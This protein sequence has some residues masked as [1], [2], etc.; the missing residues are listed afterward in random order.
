MVLSLVGSQR[1]FM[2]SRSSAVPGSPDNSQALFIK[3]A[4]TNKPSKFMITRSDLNVCTI[5][6]VLLSISI[7]VIVIP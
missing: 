7:V 4:N 1:T 5:W 2:I 6:Y 3:S